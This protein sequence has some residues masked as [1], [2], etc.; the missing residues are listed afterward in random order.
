MIRN[1][2]VSILTKFNTSNLNLEV[3]LVKGGWTRTIRQCLFV[4]QYW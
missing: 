3:K 1:R 2:I 4:E